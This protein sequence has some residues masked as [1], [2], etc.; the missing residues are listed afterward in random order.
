MPWYPFIYRIFQYILAIHSLVVKLSR[1]KVWAA[2]WRIVPAQNRL[3][4]VPVVW[5]HTASGNPFWQVGHG[6]EVRTPCTIVCG[7]V[8]LRLWSPRS[9]LGSGIW[10]NSL[11]TDI[12][13]AANT[14]R[15]VRLFPP[16]KNNS[17]STFQYILSMH[18]IIVKPFAGMIRL[19]LVKMRQW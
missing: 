13:F 15:H 19:V 16:H 2:Q 14:R 18:D 10:S 12:Y 17:Y 11:I 6:Q 7:G 5:Y 3:V 1:C 8:A 9:K 4:V